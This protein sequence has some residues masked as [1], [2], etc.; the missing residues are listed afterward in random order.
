MEVEIVPPDRKRQLLLPTGRPIGWAEWGSEQGTPVLFCTGAGMS[1]SLGFGAEAIRALGIRLLCIDRPGLG[2][3][4]PDPEKSFGSWTADVAAVL[5]AEGIE[6]P[7][8]VA[9]SQGA[10]FAVALAGAGLVSALALVAG[11]DEL[12]HPQVKALLPLQMAGLVDAI[13]A[14][15]AAFEA[16]FDTQVDA[17]GMLALVLGMSAPHDRAFYE[18]PSFLAAY[19]RA[20]QEGFAQGPAGYVRDFTLAL[21][22]WPI[23]PEVVRVPVHL[24]YGGRDTSPSHSPDFGASLE[25]R[26]PNAALHLLP[27][28]GGSLL[29]TRSGEI[30]RALLSAVGQSTR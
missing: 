9:Y 18:A 8:A 25:R 26:F 1:S 17:E 3:S 27:E 7:A 20:L 21:R 10:P 28:E 29:W 15:P 5:T 30:L 19:R 11:Q 13:A 6:R 2:R 24:W 16:S 12:A 4:A 22:P 14:D 23:Q